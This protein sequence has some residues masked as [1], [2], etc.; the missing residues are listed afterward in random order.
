MKLTKSQ[1]ERNKKMFKGHLWEKDG[2]C[3]IKWT[4]FMGTF[5]CK[6]CLSTIQAERDNS[7]SPYKYSNMTNAQGKR[8]PKK[9]WNICPADEVISK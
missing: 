7:D 9:Y 4:G 2:G 3:T 6:R 8:V 1:Q 5:T